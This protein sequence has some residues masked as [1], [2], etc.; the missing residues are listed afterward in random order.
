MDTKK[1]KT[2]LQIKPVT[3]FY[4][5]SSSKTGYRSSCKECTSKKARANADPGKNRSYYL[6]NREKILAKARKKYKKDSKSKNPTQLQQAR[7]RICNLQD[8]VESFQQ[9]IKDLETEL[10]IYK[11]RDK[12]RLHSIIDLAKGK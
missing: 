11:N 5:N 7:Q 10:L 1:C 12:Q 4:K 8:V 3:E 2:C 6:E 9:R